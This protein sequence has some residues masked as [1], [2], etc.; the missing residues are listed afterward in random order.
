MTNFLSGKLNIPYLYLFLYDS[1]IINLF[2]IFIALP[3]LTAT[4]SARIIEAFVKGK[5]LKQSDHAYSTTLM[6]TKNSSA[7]NMENVKKPLVKKHLKWHLIN[8]QC[9]VT[10][11]AVKCIGSRIAVKTM[12]IWL[13]AA[14]LLTEHNLKEGF[15]VW[16]MS[17][18][19]SEMEIL[20]GSAW[21]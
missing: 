7:P 8:S 6:C 18:L 4:C 17:S 15:A 14:A 1:F 13:E 21:T 12:F 2:A 9:V 20:I 11:T 19:P 5:V 16:E 10:S 3:L